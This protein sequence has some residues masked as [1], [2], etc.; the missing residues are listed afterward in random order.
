M[1][2]FAGKNLVFRSSKFRGRTVRCPKQALWKQVRPNSVP[3]CMR[4]AVPVP[5]SERPYFGA[6]PK[7]LTLRKTLARKNKAI[8][9]VGTPIICDHCHGT[10]LMVMPSRKSKKMKV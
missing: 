10:G 1:N 7:A 8:A 6:L 2:R 9:A 3:D 5:K 4:Y